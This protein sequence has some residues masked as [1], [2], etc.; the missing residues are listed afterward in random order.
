MARSPVRIHS[1]RLPFQFDA[2]RLRDEVASIRPDEWVSHYNAAD[3]EGEWSGVALR[4]TGGSARQLYA[5]ISSVAFLDT[6]LLERSALSRSRLSSSEAKA[7][8][9]P[10]P[11]FP[12]RMLPG[13]A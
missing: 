8:S 1:L 10:L 4:S 7:S 5:G 9:C 3:Y 2:A 12:W 6:P 13:G 11:V